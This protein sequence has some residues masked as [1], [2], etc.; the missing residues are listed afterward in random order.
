MIGEYINTA[1][2]RAHYEIIDDKER[3][4]GQVKE[5]K[6]VRATGKI[7]EECRLNL[8]EVIEGWIIIKL[9]KVLPIP[10]ICGCGIKTP[11]KIAMRI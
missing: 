10:Q 7:L 3:Y 1:L 9:K 4:Y 5:S 8:T 11:Q 2:S 6:G